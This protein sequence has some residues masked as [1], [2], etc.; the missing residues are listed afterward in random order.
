[1]KT[2]KAKKLKSGNWNIQV[3]IDGQRHSCTAPTKKEAQEKV[4]RLYAGLKEEQRAPITVGKAMDKYIE[5][6]IGILS[7]STIKGYK[8]IRK[9]YFRD[10]MDINITKL[11]QT[12]VQQAVSYE[13]IANKSPKTIRNA[14]SLLTATLAEF[15]PDFHLRT[16]FPQNR[17]KE[18][19][20]FTEEEMQKVW[21]QAK[22]N[23][24]ELPILL[25]S[26]LGLR[27]SEI[28]GLRYEDIQNGSIHVHSAIVF[29]PDGPTEKGTK[30]MSGDRWIQL[31]DAILDLIFPG[32][33]NSV[34]SSARICPYSYS[35]I[36]KNFIK[37]CKQAGV[38]PCTFHGLRHFA[39]SE[40][41]ALGIPDKYS[42][43]RMGHKTVHMLQTVYQH[44]F[45]TK[46]DE[47]A[48]LID[49]KMQDLYNSADKNAD[50]IPK[51]L[52]NTDS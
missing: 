2:P 36:Y 9:N 16:R 30:T 11:T 20:I 29:G 6:R 51:R 34:K 5:S 15:A 33:V 32:E 1:M 44:T 52:V 46:E 12:D 45:K 40:S 24:Y 14:H 39:A 42:A 17:K 13:Y 25:A 49:K 37:I 43:R 7:P 31:P 8:A 21:A 3:Q 26:W 28:L 18:P 10:L 47:F 48:M 23:K 41:L 35:A 19:R 4:R 50:E 27:V 38:E 22:G